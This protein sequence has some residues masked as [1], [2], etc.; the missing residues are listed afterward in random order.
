MSK[1]LSIFTKAVQRCLCLKSNLSPY[2]PEVAPIDNLFRSI[3]L[4]LRSWTSPKTI[5]ENKQTGFESLKDEIVSISQKTFEYTRNEVIRKC[6]EGIK[7]TITKL[8]DR[9]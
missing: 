6:L 5:K 8:N 1:C 4:K 2:F 9:N 7:L 3:K